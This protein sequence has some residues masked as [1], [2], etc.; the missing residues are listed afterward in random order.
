MNRWF[1]L[2]GLLIATAIFAGCAGVGPM[3]AAGPA[4]DAPTFRVGDRWVYRATDGFRVPV[5]WDEAPDNVPD[6]AQDKVPAS[7]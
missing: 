2:P 1:A 7:V 3:G 5:V 6:M 4:A